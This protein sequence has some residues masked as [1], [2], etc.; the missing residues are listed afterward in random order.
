MKQR[1]HSVE[2]TSPKGEPF[3]GRCTLCGK[4]GLKASAALEECENIRD[5]SVD[6][7]LIE[8]IDPPDSQSSSSEE[9]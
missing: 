3:I 5:L 7:T 6:D 4:Q 9:A 2:R 8:A 1:Y